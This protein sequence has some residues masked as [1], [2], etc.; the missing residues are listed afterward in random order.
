MD[1]VFWGVSKLRETLGGSK[2]FRPVYR[3]L[4]AEHR[5]KECQAP[6][7]GAFAFPLRMVQIRPSRKNPQ[8]CTM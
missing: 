7:D 2:A 1:P 6:F 3:H 5:C 8:L 4:P